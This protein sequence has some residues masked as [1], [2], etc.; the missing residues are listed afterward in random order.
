MKSKLSLH[1]L[2]VLC[3]LLV[4]LPTPAGQAAPTPAAA[5]APADL[6]QFSAGGHAL[7]FG[8]GGMYAASG[9][10]ALH[11]D[12]TGANSIRPQ[13]SGQDKAS[14][15]TKVEGNPDIPQGR[16]APLS[17]VTYA[18]LWDGISLAYTAETGSIYTT[19]FT[20]DAGVDPAEIR[21]RYNAPL[22]LNKDG[23]LSIA[24]ETGSMTESAPVAW[25][26]IGGQRVPVKAAFRVR[27]QEVSFTLGRYDPAFALTIDPSLVWNSFLGG[28]TGD[29]YGYSI[30][31]DSSGNTYVTGTSS[32]SWGDP[33]RAFTGGKDAYVAKLSSTG[34]LLWSTF[35]GGSGEDT[36]Y[37]ITLDA[38]GTAYVVGESTATWGIS[39]VDA[40]TGG[41]DA[42]VARLNG[43]DGTLGWNTFLGTSGEDTGRDIANNGAYIF[44]TGSS[45]AAW[46]CV[47]ASLDCVVP[48]FY[49]GTDAYAAELMADDGV[50][51]STIFLGGSG[52]DLGSGIAVK[53]SGIS[54]NV[55][56]T[57]SSYG[58]WSCD[59]PCTKRAYTADWDAFVA[60]VYVSYATL[61]QSWNTFLGGDRTDYGTDIAVDSSENLYITGF[62][63]ETWGS[64]PTRSFGAG[65][66]GY[67]AQINSSGT[68]TWNTFLGGDNMDYGYGIALDAAGTNVY[69]TGYS[70]A[71]WTCAVT[72]CTG[73]AYTGGADAFAAEL[74]ASTGN[75]FRNTFLGGDSDDNGYGV[76]VGSDGYVYTAGNSGAAWTCTTINCTANP[77][78]AGLDA[79]AVKLES[80]IVMDNWVSFIGGGGEDIGYAVDVDGSGNVYVT[81]TSEAS[82]GSPQRA[83]TSGGEA[84]V[85]KLDPSG[86]LLWNTFLGGQNTDEGAG[87]VVDAS[88]NS[89][90]T[91][92]S[93]NTWSCLSTPC[94]VRPRSVSMDGFAAKLGPSGALLWNTFLGGS[95][96][97]Q[98]RSIALDATGNIYVTGNSSAAW[99]CSY[100]IDCTVRD[101]AGTGDAFV[102][103]L[104]NSG[105]TLW[106][107]FLGGSGYVQGNGIAVDGSG[108]LYVAG[109]STSTWGTPEL[110]YTGGD[111]AFAAKID[112]SGTLLWN[113]FLGS[114]SNDE[115]L[116]VTVDGSGS[117]YVTGASQATWG[118]PMNPHSG[119]W[120][121]FIARLTSTG[122]LDWST[123]LGRSSQGIAQDGRGNLFVAGFS[124][125]SW[126]TPEVGLA[127]SF[128]A[129]AARYNADSGALTW[130]TFLGG[131]SDDYGY[132]IALDPAGDVYVAGESKSTWGTP[133]RAH[134]GGNDAF[135]VKLDPT[136][137]WVVSIQRADPNPTYAA[138]VHYTV[139]F[140]EPVT[141]VNISDFTL[142]MSGVTDAWA[143][144]VTGSGSLYTVTVTTG[145]GTGTFWLNVFDD[146]SI[147]DAVGHPLGGT[148]MGNGNFTGEVYSVRPPC[149]TLTLTHTGSGSTP[150]AVP[151]ASSGCPSGQYHAGEAITLTASPDAG[152]AVGSWSGTSN[153]SGTSTTNSLIMPSGTR[154][155]T[156]NYIQPC[157][158]L[159]RT[160]TG[161]GLDPA[162]VPP[163]SSGCSSGWHHAGESITLTANPDIGW[164]VGSWNGTSNDAST[165]I[166]NNFI[167]PAS[168]WTVTAN[169]ILINYR[170]YLPL[171]IR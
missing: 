43:T 103:K 36:G 163:T 5:A 12:F 149:Y 62:S 86:T 123:F 57:G 55:Y 133:A 131:A 1:L 37:G 164:T 107:S 162:A 66:D 106:N 150:S 40:Y 29:D 161:N 121:G 104:N 63:N 141:G 69:V 21:L 76:A 140:N 22:S 114:S 83:F 153:D 59:S 112:S 11:V 169:Y 157:Y 122:G 139:T 155:V 27:A 64:S 91:G 65:W 120:N 129:F 159:T 47:N 61:E 53:G 147:L 88:G 94:T 34:Y 97:D 51:Y 15:R 156:A 118:S 99:S 20:L 92:W 71:A 167:M 7:G 145:T 128:D 87:I 28:P 102:V 89:Y 30:A 113:S 19:T 39:P 60:E 154:T 158:A 170:I 54:F 73:R 115:A 142:T 68:L 8:V 79:F 117:V 31:V 49:G 3:L 25:Q 75:L 9:S 134:A 23:S 77:Y 6:L 52:S 74:Y 41:T 171:V 32:T 166:T 81:G 17:Q 4:A 146:D 42:F 82:W 93:Y 45:V 136:P 127:G 85:A 125:S 119:S 116:G 48:P 78:T 160:H 98:A 135:A 90:V 100:V 138:T 67:A 46:G 126:G 84:F 110:A 70:R 151:T 168:I 132:G 109:V 80:N 10:H 58:S 2:V 130:N 144:S 72:A 44:V 16:A 50:L 26:E 152:W 95:N 137:P 24:F 14:P 165:S 13:V 96:Y 101:Y 35:V 108:N 143:T 111:D 56:V 124:L 148:G 105:T 18:D 33:V 38:S